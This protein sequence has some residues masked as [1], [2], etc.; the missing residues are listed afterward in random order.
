M[1]CFDIYEKILQ[2]KQ[3][4]RRQGFFRAHN[5]K[6]LAGLVGI[7]VPPA[8]DGALGANAI[9]RLMEAIRWTEVSPVLCLAGV[10]SFSSSPGRSPRTGLPREARRR[11][12][13]T[14][15]KRGTHSSGDLAPGRRSCRAERVSVTPGRTVLSPEVCKGCSVWPGGT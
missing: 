10:A 2:I 3:E 11:R 8:I 1:V 4:S 7:G 12:G 6:T 14:G 5:Q 9:E 13:D 15:E